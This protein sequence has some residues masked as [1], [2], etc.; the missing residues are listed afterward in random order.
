MRAKGLLELVA[1]AVFIFSAFMVNM[2]CVPT[3]LEKYRVASPPLLQPEKHR[4]AA[5]KPKR[6]VKKVGP[7][8]FFISAPQKEIWPLLI[9]TLLSHYNINL[10]DRKSGVIT[11]EWDSFYL[12]GAL[13]R[14]KLSISVQKQQINETVLKIYNN[15]EYLSDSG[16]AAIWLPSDQEE[17]EVS[18][19]AKEIER[20]LH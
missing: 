17:A 6:L 18:R 20:K 12:K 19:V 8:K 10:L 2:A 1:W 9:E 5:S 13:H 3:F 16:Q 11:T 7:N 4:P 14:N 15:L